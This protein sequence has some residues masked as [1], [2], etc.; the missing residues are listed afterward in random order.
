MNNN[1]EEFYDD[2]KKIKSGKLAVFL[3]AGAS[4]DYGIP[5]MKELAD[6]ILKDL[7]KG[8]KADWFS[9]QETRESLKAILNTEKKQQLSWNAEDL[10]TR[11]AQIREAIKSENK[12]AK[13]ET[14]IGERL[15]NEK[16]IL[17]I[18][19]KIIKVIIDCFDLSGCERVQHGEK[20]VKYLSDF[21]QFLGEFQNPIRLFTT[22]NDLCI[23]AA[24][25][26]LSQLNL[27]S[28]EHK[29]ILIDGLSNGLIPTFSIDNFAIEATNPYKIP[30][31]YWKMHGSIDW[32]YTKPI[33]NERENN[34]FDDDAIIC[35][36]G[37]VEMWTSL[38]KSKAIS[39][40]IIQDA[41]RI[42]I[43]P[44]PTKYSQTYTF[45]YMDLY[46][47]FRRTLQ[48]VDMLFVVGTSF[49]DAHINSAIKSFLRRDN[50]HLYIVDPNIT[51]EIIFQKLGKHET[52]KPLIKSGF[53]DFVNEINN[54]EE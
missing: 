36:K 45:P 43:F 1:I 24:I 7:E 54:F 9:E 20:S 40:N 18:E 49:P 42:M 33:D 16:Q 34:Q 52:I 29:F 13:I 44:T 22:N 26:R 38:Y 41:S 17:N 10:L 28:Q 5:T 23:E 14:K 4:Y 32:I 3:G 12:F 51:E 6:I 39:S 2:L 19:T 37:A 50:T 15:I 47:A 30:V 35:K 25:V 21:I 46:E 27:K 31:C 48:E 11:L 8:E 53:K